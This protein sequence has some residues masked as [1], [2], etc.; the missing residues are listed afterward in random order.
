MNISNEMHA[1]TEL[2]VFALEFSKCLWLNIFQITFS[3]I[4]LI[5]RLNSYFISNDSLTKIISQQN[6]VIN[7]NRKHDADIATP[8]SCLWEI[9]D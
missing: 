9:I 4:V 5:L 7:P 6:L 3:S 2:N 1:I 8:W